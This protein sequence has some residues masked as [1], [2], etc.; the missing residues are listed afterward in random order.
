M[1]SEFRYGLHKKKPKFTKMG[2]KDWFPL[3]QLSNLQMPVLKF[4][5]LFISFV[6]D[7]IHL[8]WD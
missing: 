8:A 4:T 6:S 5:I 1:T 3:K 2:G 7:N